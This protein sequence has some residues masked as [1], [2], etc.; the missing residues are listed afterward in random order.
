MRPT[1]SLSSARSL[2]A[3]PP[4]IKP[5]APP[6]KTPQPEDKNTTSKVTAPGDGKIKDED[7]DEEEEEEEEAENC[8][9]SGDWGPA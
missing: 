3:T 8:F 1:P 6:K 7:M 5:F 9:L 4:H 2:D